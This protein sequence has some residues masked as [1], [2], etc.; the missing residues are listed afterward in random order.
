MAVSIAKSASW[1]REREALK[2]SDVVCKLLIEVSKRDCRAPNLARWDEMVA[3]DESTVVRVRVAASTVET[4]MV[5]A[6]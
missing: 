2:F 5:A 4:S 1:M 6:D 3:K